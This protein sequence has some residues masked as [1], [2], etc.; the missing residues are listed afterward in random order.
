MSEGRNRAA[1]PFV[2]VI[3]PAR[4]E[5]AYIGRTLDSLLAQNHPSGRTEILVVDGHS[6]DRTREIVR[7]IA[8]DHPEPVIRIVDNPK[9]IAAAA[10]NCGVAEARGTIVAR[11]DG[12]CEVNP[13]HLRVAVER[14]TDGDIDCVGGPIETVGETPTARAIAAAMASP[15]GVGDSA[16]RVDLTRRGAVDTVPFP[17]FRRSVL[18]AAGPFNEE[19]V[20]NQDDEYSF[21]LRK[22][23]FQVFLEPRMKSRYYSR[24]TL[25]SLWS[26]YL[27]YG[28]WKVRV[29]QKHPGQ[30]RWRHFVAPTF[31]LAL[32]IA[33]LALKS[34][35]WP[36]LV[37]MGSYFLASAWATLDTARRFRVRRAWVLPLAFAA[38]HLG[39]GAGFLFGMARFAHLW[40]SP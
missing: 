5:E 33:A 22:L 30:M 29:L 16:F 23:G 28:Y 2:S 25:S 36:F 1:P 34:S 4:N 40:R 8:A 3:L 7:H 20:R 24:G 21:R 11:V 38:L 31:V 9:Q 27:Q 14:L 12:H 32:L 19:L 26:Q 35:P 10:L 17:A 39:Y 18:E 37:L 6:S 15:F 13:D